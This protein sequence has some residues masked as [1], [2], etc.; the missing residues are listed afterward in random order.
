MLP[1]TI[2]VPYPA[3]LVFNA[4]VTRYEGQYVMV[5]R[6]DHGRVGDPGF[7]GTNLGLAFSG[8]GILWEVQPEPCFAWSDDDVIR[9]YDPRH[10]PEAVAIDARA[11]L[12]LGERDQSGA[13]VRTHFRQSGLAF[14]MIMSNHNMLLRVSGIET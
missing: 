7:D 8:D 10:V 1:R 4:G 5:F 14:N 2:A 9:A 6:N 11:F 3:T 12:Q 13:E